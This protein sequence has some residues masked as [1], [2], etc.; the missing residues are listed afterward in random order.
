LK[1][2]AQTR[3]EYPP[4]GGVLKGF[5]AIIKIAVIFLN[6]L[7]LTARRRKTPFLRVI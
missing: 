3:S 5:Q 4:S 6:R 7:V 1:N 2:P